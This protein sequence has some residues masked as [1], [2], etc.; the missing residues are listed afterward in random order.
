MDP[1]T[2]FEE[3]QYISPYQQQQLDNWKNK[4][5]K[6]LQAAWPYFYRFLNEFLLIMMKVIRGSIQIVKDQLFNKM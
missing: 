4:I 1:N 2:Q 6:G 5:Q 3:K